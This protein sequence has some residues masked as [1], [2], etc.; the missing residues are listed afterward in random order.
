MKKYILKCL[1]FLIPI[2]IIGNYYLYNNLFTKNLGD[3]IKYFAILN[4]G[5]VIVLA[6]M[7]QNKKE[8]QKKKEFKKQPTKEELQKEYE[9]QM[10]AA[11]QLQI[12]NII[13]RSVYLVFG[14]IL[15]LGG[16]S[17]IFDSKEV[18]YFG[19]VIITTGLLFSIFSLFMLRKWILLYKQFKMEKKVKIFE[20]ENTN[21]S[22]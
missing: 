6:T 3:Y 14:I 8:L 22:D 2:V 1:I 13:I 18:Q 10:E 16:F 20:D 15:T 19:I 5:A 21:H 12:Q 4:V 9:E 7:I 11:A 17:I